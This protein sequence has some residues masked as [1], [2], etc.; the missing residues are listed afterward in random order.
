MKTFFHIKNLQRYIVL[1][2]PHSSEVLLRRQQLAMKNSAGEEV[3]EEGEEGEEGG[4]PSKRKGKGKGKG[5]GRGQPKA[6]AKAKARAKAKAKAKGKG[7]GD[8]DEE[9]TLEA[10]DVAKKVANPRKRAR[11]PSV[12]PQEPDVANAST[13]GDS[14]DEPEAGAADDSTAKRPK[15]GKGKVSKEPEQTKSNNIKDAE[16]IASL[17]SFARR[18]RPSTAFSAAKWAAIRE[19]FHQHIR[20]LASNKA[21]S[22]EDNGSKEMF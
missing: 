2:N 19:A 7:K 3:A 21:S 12:V 18:P 17:K 6:K 10:D 16:E 15:R 11:K 14:K 1:V 4:C 5:R 22:H 9:K 13:R 8:V 20:D